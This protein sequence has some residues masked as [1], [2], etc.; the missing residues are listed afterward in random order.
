MITLLQARSNKTMLGIVLIL[1][2]VF[3]GSIQETLFKQFG[4]GLSL[5]Q[6][7]TLR[8]LF[9][10]PLLFI[11]VFFKNRQTNLWADA[12]GKW[13]LLRSLYMTLMFIAI[14]SSM[15]FLNLST[16]AAG[17][18]TSPIFVTLLS[19]YFIN[20]SVTIRGWIAIVMGFGGALAI[21]QPG[22]D[23]FNFWS[24]LPVLA[25]FLYALSNV[26]TRSKCQNVSMSALTL[27]LN[28]ALL[29][30]GVLFSGILLIWQPGGEL[31]SSFPYLFGGWSRLGESEWIFISLLVILV[32]VIG[33]ALAGAYQLAPPPTVATFDYT[34]LILM[35]F[36]D[37]IL[38]SNVPGGM[39]AFGI[40]L[41]VAAGLLV[42]RRNRPIKN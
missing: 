30:T 36:W 33:M 40:L 35:A 11:F 34:Y 19:A 7:F 17:I 41:I 42:T 14:Y 8:G 23:A 12:L 20:E 6:I 15:P 31:L 18:Y 10:V 3:L 39:T 16:I 4:A 22:T 38:F 1:I 9:A 26:T 13:S 24:V 29:M 32:I 21:L 25:G 37:Y 5:W 2:A 27:S 28:L